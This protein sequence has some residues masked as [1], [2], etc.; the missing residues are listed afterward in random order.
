MHEK[1]KPRSFCSDHNVNLVEKDV[2]V[3]VEKAPMSKE[4]KENKRIDYT[5]DWYKQ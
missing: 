1:I 5:E 4:D 3:Q 2:P